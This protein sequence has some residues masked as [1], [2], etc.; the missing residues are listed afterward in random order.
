MT[1]KLPKIL[2]I[3]YSPQESTQIS[4]ELGV[5][6]QRGYLA[7]NSAYTGG[8]SKESAATIDF[9]IPE[10]F[11]EY[12][13]IFMNFNI[14]EKVK[15]E[16][17]EQISGNY[18][19]NGKNF[20]TDFWFN[21]RGYLVIFTGKD[22]VNLSD[23]GVPLEAS[24]ALKTDRTAR[25]GIRLNDK[26]FFR[27]SLSEQTKNI[28]MPASHYI[29]VGEDNDFSAY[30]EDG[31]LDRAYIN[32]S[33]KPIGVYIDGKKDVNDYGWEDA[34]QV[35]VLPEFKSLP[36][37]T[38]ALTNTFSILSPK[39][40]PL[41]STDWMNSDDYYPNSITDY[42]VKITETKK[43]AQQRVEDLEKA[44]KTEAI[45]LSAYIGVLT[46]SG[47]DLVDSVNWLLTNILGLKVVDVDAEK[48]AGNN[49]EDLLI[50]LDNGTSILA[51]VKGTKA[52]YPSP[53]YIGQATNHFIRKAKLGAKKCILIVNHDYETEP[54][55]RIN[56]YTGDD[57][58]L[59]E[60]VE[61]ISY[62]DTR[63]LHKICLDVANSKLSLD[64]AVSIITGN[65]RIEY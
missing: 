23:L 35:M 61:Y 19:E 6:I 65:A 10:S 59:L 4:I 22:L 27:K 34:P 55:M 37:I 7:S 12:Q 24:K 31:R 5:E 42:Q 9:Y 52:M 17:K 2:L 16:F 11:A 64:D 54:K 44:K 38:T 62:L 30:L 53:K 46:Q 49:K 40:L 41:P 32:S 45:K 13:A 1:K 28:K 43:I 3:N 33:S 8:N 14:S 21:N 39:F 29:F 50:T 18:E 51:E 25:L 60:S 47:N 63:V 26:N 48:E 56:A 57:S 20:L 58:D 15:T 36:N